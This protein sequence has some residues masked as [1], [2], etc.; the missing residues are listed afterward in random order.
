M[1]FNCRE[2]LLKGHA[3]PAVPLA[4]TSG[5][6]WDENS[7]A[8]LIRYYVD[9]GAG[10]LA[11]GVHSTQFAIRSPKVGLF[12]PVLE[13]AAGEVR[14]WS[15]ERK[16]LCLIAGLCGLT[17]QAV[18][19]GQLARGL[20]YHAGLLSL[21]ALSGSP[22]PQIIKHC[23]EV[24]RTIPL[25]G[26]YLQPAAGGLVLSRRFWNQFCEIENVV[27]VKIAPFNRYRTVDVVRAVLETE[28]DDVALYTGNDDN[29]V[30][31]LMTP[32]TFNGRT[33]FIDG[34]LLGHWG[35]WTRRAIEL[36][37][38]IR[39][40][41]RRKLISRRWLE[42]GAAITDAN[43]A[44]FDPA[45]DFRGCIPGI[46]EVLRRQGL[47]KSAACLDPEER[48]S[49]GQASAITRVTKTYPWMCDDAF[50]ARNLERWRA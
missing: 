32:F 44:I 8:A 2:S 14:A 46:H 25:V 35:I 21:G 50:V 34:G 30:A 11:V 10:G 16:P 19:E 36:F 33:R 1:N 6:K 3:I 42:K 5:R 15:G 7:Q 13:L 9:A 37:D 40:A 43:A 39:V 24:A 20:G 23:R 38:E 49:P 4:L 18:F 48:L 31:D 17:K 12:R 26:F 28:R 27:A 45:N 47:I 29:I 41:R 22:E